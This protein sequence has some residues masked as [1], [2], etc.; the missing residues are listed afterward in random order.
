MEDSD[1]KVTIPVPKVHELRTPLPPEGRCM[2]CRRA[3]R[4]TDYLVCAPCFQKA[5]S[6]IDNW[7]ARG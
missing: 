4:L 5:Q 7:R 3:D 2:A 1:D 6:F